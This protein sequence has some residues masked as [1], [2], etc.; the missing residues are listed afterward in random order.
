[1]P[2]SPSLSPQRSLPS[3]SNLSMLA[4]QYVIT[5]PAAVPSL[6]T[7]VGRLDK[8]ITAVNTTL[9]KFSRAERVNDFETLAGRI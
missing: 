4:L 7:Y 3:T 2:P 8:F 9:R 5:M 6:C 1:M